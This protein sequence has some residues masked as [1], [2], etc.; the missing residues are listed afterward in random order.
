MLKRIFLGLFAAL[1][2]SISAV[3]DGT[4]T[5]VGAG[6]AGGVAPPATITYLSQNA[7][8]GAGSSQ[9]IS[10]A[11]LGTAAA[12]RYIVVVQTGVLQSACTTPTVDIAG[13]S[14][15][16]I[17]GTA[18]SRGAWMALVPTG[19]TGNIVYT[20][21]TGTV[22]AWINSVY[23]LTDLQSTTPVEFFDTG[24]PSTPA[25]ST[26]T[27]SPDGVSLTMGHSTSTTATPTV[28]L[29]GSYTS[30]FANVQ[31]NPSG[32]RFYARSGGSM[33]TTGASVSASYACTGVSFSCQNVSISFR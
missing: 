31:S 7:P 3:A 26:I 33:T 10:G 8:G 28:A 9:T 6:S 19:T 14:A 30:N 16:L 29:T 18:T 2:F 13:V 23:R 25:A 27:T 4:L 17:G 12:N 22:S 32:S 11:S 21:T 5:L 20:C 24:G 1:A 15:T